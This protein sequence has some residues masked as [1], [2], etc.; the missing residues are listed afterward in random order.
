MVIDLD[1]PVAGKIKVT[2]IPIKLSA[3]PGEVLTPPP[4][5]GQH[6]EEILAKMLGYSKEKIEELKK[7]K[8]V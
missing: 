1:H 7:N 5:L 6:T 2:G 4:T 3:T 8:V